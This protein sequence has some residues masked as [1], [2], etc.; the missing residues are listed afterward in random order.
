MQIYYEFPIKFTDYEGIIFIFYTFAAFGKL[1]H[2]QL[3]FDLKFNPSKFASLC[4][5]PIFSIGNCVR[6]KKE[7]IGRDLLYYYAICCC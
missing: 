4:A 3:P 5:C 7:F 6:S 1:G 2:K